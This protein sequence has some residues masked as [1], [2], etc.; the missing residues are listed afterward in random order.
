M[1]TIL[2]PSLAARWY[3]RPLLLREGVGVAACVLALMLLVA[4][5]DPGIQL[6]GPAAP[7]D[8]LRLLLLNAVPAL[9]LFALLLGLTRRLLLSSWLVL[10]ALAGLYAANTAKLGTL[11]TPLLPAD[12]RFL[13]EPGPAIELFSK[14]LHVDALRWVLIAGG[15]A[16]TVALMRER[17]LKALA[18]WRALALGTASIVLGASLMAGASPWRRVYHS[19]EATFQPWA[20]N[21]SS[22][23]TGLIGR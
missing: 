17:R 23:H 10:L 22:V 12:L 7:S 15:A 4:R 5:L 19:A 1:K 14:Y 6:G 18:G 9:T 21:E 16:L 3:G 11:E 20:L 8:A 13:A 2:F